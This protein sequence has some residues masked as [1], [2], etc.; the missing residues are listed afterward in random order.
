MV[1]GPLHNL[2]LKAEV[3]FCV[4][5]VVSPVL[6]NVFLHYVF[7]LRWLHLFGQPDGRAKVYSG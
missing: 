7:D 1:C 3:A 5:G 2:A 6:A 4:R